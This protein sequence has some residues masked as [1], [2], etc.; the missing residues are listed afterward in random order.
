M[1]VLDQEPACWSPFLGILIRRPF[2]ILKPLPLPRFSQTIHKASQLASLDI[3][4][5]LS[6]EY[7]LC[8]LPCLMAFLISA[9]VRLSVISAVAPTHKMVEQRIK[10]EM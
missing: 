5:L 2:G 3:V 7:Q 8:P 10:S 6:L 4:C 9:L 1:T